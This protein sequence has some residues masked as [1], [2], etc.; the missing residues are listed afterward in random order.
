MRYFEANILFLLKFF[1][2]ILACIGGFCLQQWVLQ[3]SNSDFLFPSLILQLLI[4]ILLKGESAFPLQS[5]IYSIIYLYRMGSWLYIFLLGLK[6]K[7]IIIHFVA[8]SIL[9]CSLGAIS[10][11]CLWLFNMIPPLGVW[12]FCFSFF[13]RTEISWLLILLLLLLSHILNFFFPCNENF[14][15][16][17]SLFFFLMYFFWLCWVFTAAHSSCGGRG[18][19]FI[20]V[21]RFSSCGAPP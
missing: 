21:H 11:W 2:W 8:E 9:V 13:L 3:C 5:F 19:L 14:L 6:C 7:T 18:L 12:L 16:V 1:P 15:R 17:Y 10:G 4:G 20:S